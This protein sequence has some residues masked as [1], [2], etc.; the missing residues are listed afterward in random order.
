MQTEH[1]INGC[2]ISVAVFKRDV[3]RTAKFRAVQMREH[4]RVENFLFFSL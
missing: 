2:K 1:F 4:V 3:R